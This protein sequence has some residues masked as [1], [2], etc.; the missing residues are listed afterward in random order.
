MTTSSGTTASLDLLPYGRVTEQ[1]LQ[2]LRHA[3]DEYLN[4][5]TV[6]G[7]LRTVVQRSWSRCSQ[8][9]VRPD[10]RTL[11]VRAEPRLNAT[12]Q[13]VSHAILRYLAGRIY[14]TRAA[15]LLTDD[16]GIIADWGGDGEV[17]R[18]LEQVQTVPGA[19]LSEEL[20]GTNAIGTALAEGIGV[21]ICSGE[22]FIEAFQVFACT[23]I[24]IRH[25]LTNQVL[26]VLDLTTR[27]QDISP[28]V[29]RLVTRAAEAIQ[30]RLLEELTAQ[31]RA[32]LYHYL[33]QH[34]R[35]RDAIIAFN[36]Y[37]TISSTA[38]LRMLEQADYAI[39]W[40]LMEEGLRT[41]RPFQRE[42]M[43]VSGQSV[44][45]RV[46]PKFDGG[47]PVGIILHIEPLT[48]PPP[49][50]TAWPVADPFAHLVG[51][52]PAFRRALD[53]ARAAVNSGLPVLVVGETG[54]GKYALAEAMA[55]AIGGRN[56]TIECAGLADDVQVESWAAQVRAA[57][58]QASVV[59][60]RHL[61]A[62]PEAAQRLLLGLLAQDGIT[63]APR[64]IAT[65]RSATHLP[66]ELV[67][68][69]TAVQI[70]L[71]P[72]R[73]R[74]EDIPLLV[75][76]ALGRLQPQRRPRVSCEVLEL[77]SNADW[78]GNV[79]Q[80]EHILCSA[81][82]AARGWEITIA[83]LPA[84]FVRDAR[85]TRLARLEQAEIDEIRRALHEA[86]GN[87]VKAA[88]ILGISRSTLYR[89]LD[90]YRRL[91]VDLES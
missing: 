38:A 90:M 31:E 64:R 80:L 52:S 45:V 33:Q 49:K 70:S 86:K 18:L 36:G 47:T 26:A 10:M 81:L 22:H 87:R 67:D 35:Q 56:L 15:V 85:R 88:A 58:E 30:E 5:R 75:Q 46:S 11:E 71:P 66:R 57:L 79:R 41:S 16:R 32:L 20:T 42:I 63:P 62:L 43:L 89:K 59:I 91:G 37:T 78:P 8:W 65:A 61:D 25:P 68:R 74:R 34:R 17:R 28:S 60:F 72:L 77:L 1:E 14:R 76:A 83:D 7:D 48:P 40:P 21:Q 82:L 54:S 39:L 44:R 6:T 53:T 2:R 24:P 84:E 51:Q 27:A 55:G 3:R 13:R 12:V 50:P 4:R 9:G 19:A 23:A 29:A 73:E 69:V